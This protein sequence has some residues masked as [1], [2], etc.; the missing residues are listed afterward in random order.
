MD[1][2]FW[3]VVEMDACHMILGRPWQFDVD[4][5]HKGRD[6][7]YI[8]FKDKR[9]IV[10][11]PLQEETFHTHAHSLG[12]QVLLTTGQKFLEDVREAREIIALVPNELMS[13]FNKRS[14]LCCNHGWKSSRTSWLTR[15]STDYR[16]LK[17]YN[18]ILTWC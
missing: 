9:K 18:T 11:R 3:D 7:V 15:C 16:L 5:Q 2:T 13:P 10:L 4:A 12:K 17:T 14:S 1:T 8:L 6:N